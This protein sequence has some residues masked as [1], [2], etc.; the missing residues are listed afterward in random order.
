MKVLIAG[1]TGFM[2][3]HLI[4]SLTA[5]NHKV[6]VLSRNSNQMIKGTQ[7]VGWDGK[8]TNGW[9]QLMEEMDA[10][11]NLS[12]LSLYAWPWTKRKKQ[13]FLDS[14]VEPG[15]ALATAIKE[16]TH[17]P[18]IFVQISGINQSL[19]AYLS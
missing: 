5:D 1:G 19:P 4:E 3:K 6:W 8:T 10:V 17:R 18:D 15:C 2:G 12:G 16:A 11:I 14:R 7:V 9:G 13:R